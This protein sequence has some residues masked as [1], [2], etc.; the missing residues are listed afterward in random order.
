MTSLVYG[1]VFPVDSYAIFVTSHAKLTILVDTIL[2]T[3]K[4]VVLQEVNGSKLIYLDNAATSQKPTAV[5][6]ALQNYYATYN[7]NVHRGIHYLR[8]RLLVD[9]I[10]INKPSFILFFS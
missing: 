6:K 4:N 3:S 8:Y 10:S 1:N 7:S 9:V 5:L 2:F